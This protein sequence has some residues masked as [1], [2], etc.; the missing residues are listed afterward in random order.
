M[1]F[2]DHIHPRSRLTIC[3]QANTSHSHRQVNTHTQA[4]QHKRHC[5]MPGMYLIEG[6]SHSRQ[7]TSRREDV[8]EVG[9]HSHIG[10]VNSCEK[11]RRRLQAEL[12]DHVEREGFSAVISSS[13]VISFWSVS[14][15]RAPRSQFHCSG[16]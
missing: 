5:S 1:A 12:L 6:V 7:H 3:L 13:A 14:P 15:G 11:A 4:S 2:V 9:H 16:C 10:D 8:A